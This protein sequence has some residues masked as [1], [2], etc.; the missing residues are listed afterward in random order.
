MQIWVDADACPKVIKEILYRAAT[1]TGVPLVLVANVPLRTPPGVPVR[2]VLV[3]AGMDAADREIARL[4]EPGDLV[5]TADIPLA[6]AAIEKG[7]CALDPRGTLYTVDNI[8]ERLTVRNLLDELRGAGLE[9][10][11]PAPFTPADRLAFANAL[12]RLL[13]RRSIR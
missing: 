7:A 1:R 10:G 9:G 4:A 13:A 8:A 3:A 6:A 5:V 2:T 12:D 11:G